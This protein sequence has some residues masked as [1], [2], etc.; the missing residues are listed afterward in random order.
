MPRKKKSLTLKLPDEFIDLCNAH[1]TTPT[2]VL[3]S[4]IADV[5]GIIDWCSD[6]R[7]DGYQ[8]GGSDER[9]KA[10]EYFQRCGYGFFKN[11]P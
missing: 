8:S 2:I 3:R 4:F 7:T 6:P 11:R 1:D 10:F 9:G 5:S